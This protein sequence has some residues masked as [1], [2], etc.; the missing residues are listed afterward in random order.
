MI[1]GPILQDGKTALN[2]YL[3]NIQAPKYVK[4]L[5]ADLTEHVVWKTVII[6]DFI[7]ALSA[8]SWP[9]RLKINQ[10]TKQAQS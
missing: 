2:I 10:S 8:M 4:G 6:E 5:L 3:S 1:M 7:T 9:S